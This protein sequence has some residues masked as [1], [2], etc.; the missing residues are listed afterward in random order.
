MKQIL[1][2]W[3]T[4]LGQPICP[5]NLALLRI[6]VA[7]LALGACWDA[8]WVCDWMGQDGP[9]NSP[10]LVLPWCVDVFAG[11]SSGTV[12]VWLALGL[13][14][15][16]GLLLGLG[17]RL[18]NLLA[19]LVCLSLRNE[20][21][22]YTMEG[23]LQVTQCLLFALLWTPCAQVWSLDRRF[24]LIRGTP[25]ASSPWPLR[26]LQWLQIVIYLESGYYKLMGRHW[27]EGQA[28][29]MGSQNYNFCKL[30]AYAPAAGSWMV[31]LMQAM[32]WLVL[33]WELTFPLWML[34]RYSRWLSILIGVVM[35]ASLWVAF[36]IAL[37][38]PAM[39][40]LYF[41]Y[42]PAQWRGRPIPP[43]R[44]LDGLA[45]LFLSLHAVGVLW[46]ALPAEVVYPSDPQ[47]ASGLVWLQQGERGLHQLRQALLDRFPPS[48]WLL[49]YVNALSVAHRYN[50][51]APNPPNYSV[52]FRIRE[53]GGRL[54]WTDF[55]GQGRRYSWEVV[56]VRAV[57]EQAPSL[58]PAI[59]SSFARR[60]GQE[61][62]SVVLEEY[63][64]ELGATGDPA[65]QAQFNRRWELSH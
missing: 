31:P 49:S 4:R 32:T 46:A 9:R 33:F 11:A 27:Y 63:L 36:D 10:G 1:R 23:G 51:F 44:P 43:V 57:A 26:F 12:L 28:L 20:L 35:H 15:S 13:L 7:L 22:W 59:L 54:L 18:C 6:L 8:L 16:L 42:L 62:G 5:E 19:W 61:H 64:L 65:E 53:G 50:T 24:G 39:I 56:M 48:R 55:P 58:L 37:Y 30:A 47:Q 25:L 52:F 38:P 29:W 17:T 60:L 40:V 3:W 14:A 2:D 41:T 21:G 34:H 45:R